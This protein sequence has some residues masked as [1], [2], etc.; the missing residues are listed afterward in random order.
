MTEAKLWTVK[1]LARELRVHPATVTRALVKGQ[2]KGVRP[3]GSGHWRVTQQEVERLLGV[4][5]ETN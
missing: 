4:T 5:N 2:I 3:M 1:E